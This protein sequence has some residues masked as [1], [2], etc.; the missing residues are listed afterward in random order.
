[1]TTIMV[2]AVMVTGLSLASDRPAL[3][4]DINSES[5]RYDVRSGAYHLSG[6]VR[7]TRGNLVVLA[8]EAKSFSGADGQVERIELYGNPTTWSDVLDDGSA[9]EGQSLEIIYDFTRNIIT[10]QGDALIRNVQGAFRGSKLVYDLDSE[11]LVGDGGVNLVIEP[12]TGERARR[13]IPEP[14]DESDN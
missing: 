4:I 9:V 10:M 6:N 13:Q 12:E 14:Q 1:M 7:I 2:L 11:D 8:D 5:G 3:P